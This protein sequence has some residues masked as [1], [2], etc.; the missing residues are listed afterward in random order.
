MKAVQRIL[1]I[2]FLIGLAVVF[3]FCLIAGLATLQL[4]G[5]TDAQKSFA[6]V[7]LAIAALC[8]GAFLGLLLRRKPRFE[9][10]SPSPAHVRAADPEHPP[11]PMP[12]PAP[13]VSEVV[14]PSMKAKSADPAPNNSR[15]IPLP[16]TDPG[17]PF[18]IEYADMDGVVTIRDIHPRRFDWG[19]YGDLRI[20]AYCYLRSEVRSFS[21]GQILRCRHNATNRPL[22]DLAAYLEREW[23]FVVPERN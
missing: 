17:H 3:L 8:L 5:A 4:T 23:G 11:V 20:E 21:S 12:A 6:G 18:T 7:V 13:P 9:D 16:P 22:S 14:G 1:R 10:D 15:P 19:F 2:V